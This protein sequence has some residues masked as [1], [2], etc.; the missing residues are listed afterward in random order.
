[1]SEPKHLADLLMV[2][3]TGGSERLIPYT[4]HEFVTFNKSSPHSMLVYSRQEIK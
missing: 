2:A 4:G 1:M 3:L